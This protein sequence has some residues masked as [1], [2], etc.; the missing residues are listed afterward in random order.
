MLLFLATSFD[1]VWQGN[2]IRS[3]G[4]GLPVTRGCFAVGPKG[5][6]GHIVRKQTP[7]LAYENRSKAHVYAIRQ[8]RWPRKRSRGSRKGGGAAGGGGGGAR[9]ARLATYCHTYL[10]HNPG[11]TE[12]AALRGQT[13]HEPAFVLV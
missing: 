9:G 2:G 6:C 12:L 5:P 13:L 3:T 8:N 4:V 11:Y 7:K 1:R 10:M